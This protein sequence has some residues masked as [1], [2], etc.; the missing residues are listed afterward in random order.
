MKAEHGRRLPHGELEA[1]HRHGRV[2][3]HAGQGHG[4][5]DPADQADARRRT[6]AWFAKYLGP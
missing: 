4:L 5:R 2:I 6:L 1:C 3:R